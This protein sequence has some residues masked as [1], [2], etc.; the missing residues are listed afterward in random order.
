MRR[1]FSHIWYFLMVQNWNRETNIHLFQKPLGTYNI[2]TCMIAFT[3]YHL[4]WWSLNCYQILSFLINFHQLL[5]TYRNVRIQVS[6]HWNTFAINHK[7]YKTAFQQL[8]NKIN[9]YHT[10]KQQK[11]VE[12]MAFHVICIMLHWTAKSRFIWIFRN[13]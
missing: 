8:W 1:D 9:G 13:F 3:K 11:T 6:A 12:I 4:V 5:S 10:I 7:M 2:C